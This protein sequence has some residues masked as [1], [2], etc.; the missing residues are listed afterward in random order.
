M[1]A[2]LVL[3]CLLGALIG[4]V[5]AVVGFQEFLALTVLSV[6][7]GLGLSVVLAVLLI[8]DSFPRHV[9]GRL[10]SLEHQLQQWSAVATQKAPEVQAAPGPAPAATEP[11][12]PDDAVDGARPAPPPPSDDHQAP[13][14]PA[15]L[16]PSVRKGSWEFLVGSRVLAAAGMVVS[17]I[18]LGLFLKLGWDQG[19]LRPS[20]ALRVLLGGAAGL[21]LLALAEAAARRSRYAVLAQVLAAGGVSSL[22]LS[23]WAAHG[24]YGLVSLGAAFALVVAAAVLGVGLAVARRARWVA[25]LSAAGGLLAPAIL[26]LETPSPL[27]LYAFLTVLNLAV[28]AVAVFRRWPETGA[29]ALLGTCGHALAAMS[30]TWPSGDT[31]LLDTAWLAVTLVV[32]LGI[33]TAGAGWRRQPLHIG[34]QGV[35]VTAS[36]VFWAGGLWRLKP[37]GPEVRGAW[38]LLVMMLALGVAAVLFRRWGRSDRSRQGFVA[39]AAALAVALPPVLWHGAGMAAAWAVQA[40]ALGVAAW[41]RGWR[42]AGRLA[43]GLAV[44]AV[45]AAGVSRPATLSGPL[46]LNSGSLAR[47]G[48]AAALAA[49]LVLAERLARSGA[50]LSRLL[51]VAGPAAS[52]ALFFWY[53]PEVL[54]WALRVTEPADS[55]PWIAL[56]LALFSAAVGA[57][58]LAGWPWPPRAVTAITGAM[59]L[60]AVLVISPARQWEGVGAAAA[61]TAPILALALALAAVAWRRKQHPRTLERVVVV[62]GIVAAGL[63]GG[64]WRSWE[65]WPGTSVVA[66]GVW[67]ALMLIFSAG[68]AWAISRSIR[69]WPGTAWRW[70]DLAAWLLGTAAV[71]RLVAAA[72]LYGGDPATAASARAAGLSLSVVWG[73]AGVA[74]LLAGLVAR[75]TWRRWAGLT[76]LGVTVIKVFAWDLASTA[77][78]IRIVAVLACGGALVAGSFLYARLGARLGEDQP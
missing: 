21:G 57:G 60:A 28:L 13:P 76:A 1:L 14:P 42:P 8:Q 45:V 47:L 22:Y 38:T 68:A 37:F 7:A 56:A 16:P 31:R 62:A 34:E 78:G 24:L 44:A 46:L 58:L 3:A 65:G 49:L 69:H 12:P 72:V 66:D 51:A 19:W 52:L 30:L 63:A 35:L 50:R 75:A 5:G 11:P 25:L 40:L 77:S 33:A 15:T 55:I 18:A 67:P 20:P 71:S 2:G 74:A 43:A 53:E 4:L 32:F 48:A 59:W 17:V 54:E 27:G 39:V 26:P 10:E 61:G 9:L 64:F 41:R 36:L 73:G 29:A 70:P 6:L 23:A